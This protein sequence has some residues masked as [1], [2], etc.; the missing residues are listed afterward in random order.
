MHLQ[1]Q[2]PDIV[3]VSP[4][5]AQNT[6]T[7][8]RTCAGLGNRLHIVRPCGFTFE[9]RYLR[10]AGLDYWPSVKLCIHESWEMFLE[11]QSG[12]CIFL[13]TRGKRVLTDLSPEEIQATQYFVFGSES[14]GFPP[15]FYETYASELV[16]LPVDLSAIRSFNLAVSVGMALGIAVA[17]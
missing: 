12:P 9:S 17:K 1:K 14:S 11:F 2:V 3:L 15:S 10:R 4:V 5:I 8:A 16:Q 7:I 6:G 13:S